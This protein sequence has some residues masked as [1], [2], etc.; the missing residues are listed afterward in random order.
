MVKMD[1]VIARPQIGAT[2]PTGPASTVTGPTGPT[3]SA[4]MVWKGPWV[5]STSYVPG[6]VVSSAGISYICILSNSNHIPPDPTY[7]EVVAEKGD[8][9][10][11]G[12]TGATGDRGNTGAT[13]ITGTTGPSGGPTGPTGDTGPTGPSGGP[14]GPT[15][16]TGIPGVNWLGAWV[17]TTT[18]Q[19]N[20]A[21]SHNGASYIATA[22]NVNTQPPNPACWDVLTAKGDTG[23]TGPTGPTGN[24]GVTGPSGTGPTGPSGPTGPTGPTGHTG[25]GSIIPGPPGPTGPTGATG[26][27]STVTGPTGPTGATGPKGADSTVTGPTGPTGSTGPTGPLGPT[28]P[29][30]D[31]GAAVTGATGPTGPS[32]GP[33]G[34]T[35]PTGVTGA[36]VGLTWNNVTGTAVDGVADNGY[37]ANNVAL[38][39]ITLPLVSL[40]GQCVAVSD[41]GAGGGWVLAQRAGQIIHFLD[42][43]T[44]IGTAGSIASVG[45]Y[46]SILLRCIV[47][48]T[49]WYVET[50]TG[51]LT[52]V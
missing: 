24:V 2:G 49:T 26:A 48:N 9:G 12:S 47:E 44:T 11:A 18:Y 31:T 45:N 29:T 10:A 17:Y 50:A 36:G 7:W 43:S 40:I 15:G 34:P 13:G 19:I 39:T 51:N 28:G 5:F 14:S 42:K 22:I 8:T 21:V 16:P 30:G 32:G 25:A 1:I 38:V 23:A 52:V 4:G 20:D 3:G 41:A 6:D 37:I 27:D 46:N 35:G 33:V